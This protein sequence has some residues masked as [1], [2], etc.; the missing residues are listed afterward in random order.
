MAK[1]DYYEVL[2]VERA[3]PRARSRGRSGSPASSTPTSTRTTPGRGEVQG[4]GR[5]LRGPLRSRGRRPTTAS[6]TR[7]SLW[8]FEP[9]AG[10]WSFQDIFD[11]LFGAAILSAAASA[12]GA[13]PGRDVAAIVE[14]DL[15]EV[16]E[17]QRREVSFE[18]MSVCEH[19]RG[20]GAEPGIRRSRPAT[21]RG[22]G[23]LREVS[24]SVFGQVDAGGRLRPLRGQ[25]RVPRHPCEAAVAPGGEGRGPGRWTSPPGSRTDSGSGSRGGPRG[26]GGGR[27]GDLYVE[28]R[29][30]RTSASPARA[31]SWSARCRGAGDDGDA[32]RGGLVPTLDGEMAVKVPAGT[33]HGDVTALAGA[34]CLPA[35]R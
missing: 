12:R 13:A 27:Q 6:A 29:I 31:R 28:V 25:G 17:E 22:T 35:R 33:Q 24:R 30:E 18:A 16:L 11:A 14:I 26:R 3:P 2:G 9:G 15:S 32:R 23:Q 20:N 7:A 21:L 10:F 4:G 19:C 34:G 8:R 1:R 5:G